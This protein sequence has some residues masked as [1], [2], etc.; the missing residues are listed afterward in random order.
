MK[1]SCSTYV[2]LVTFHV[3]CEGGA[4][5]LVGA[6]EA[7]VTRDLS[8]YGGGQALEE[9][10]R[11]LVPYDGFHHRPDWALTEERKAGTGQCPNDM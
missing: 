11:P 1:M 2:V 5:E 3:V 8:G 9:A 10:E 7:E 6:E 4:A